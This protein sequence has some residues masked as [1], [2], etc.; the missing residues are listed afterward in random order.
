MGQAMKEQTTSSIYNPAYVMLIMLIGVCI[1]IFGGGYFF[2]TAVSKECVKGIEH[3]GG[4]CATTMRGYGD[5]CLNTTK[6]GMRMYNCI[7]IEKYRI[8]T[9]KNPKY[10]NGSEIICDPGD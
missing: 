1:G 5:F 7:W 9:G 6:Q 2:G 3:V 8:D 10:L 4:Y